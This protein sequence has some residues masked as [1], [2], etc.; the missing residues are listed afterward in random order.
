MTTSHPSEP[1]EFDRKAAAW[2]RKHYPGAQPAV[3]SVEFAMDCAAYN[4]GAWAN[5]D[6]SWYEHDPARTLTRRPVTK[7][8]DDEAWQYDAT[9]LLRELVEMDDPGDEDACIPTR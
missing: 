9:A 7:T 2:V 8:I 1:G 5:F 3:G 4:S 6:V